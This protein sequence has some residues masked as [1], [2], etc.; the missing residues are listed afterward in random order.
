M[1]IIQRRQWRQRSATGGT[2]QANI[3]TPSVGGGG[4]GECPPRSG[5]RWGTTGSEKSGVA[6][7]SL[8]GEICRQ[9]ASATW[10]AAEG[11]EMREMRLGAEE[12]WKT[13]VSA[14][15]AGKWIPA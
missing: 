13:T 12:R 9:R 2:Y 11:W 8:A 1:V 10:A 5:E 14:L 15:V 4:G 3:R 7:E 6:A